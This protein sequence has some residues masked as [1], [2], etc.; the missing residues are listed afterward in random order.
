VKIENICLAKVWMVKNEEKTFHT[1]YNS[2]EFSLPPKIK[3]SY[4]E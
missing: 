4:V 1:H 2:R 3:E